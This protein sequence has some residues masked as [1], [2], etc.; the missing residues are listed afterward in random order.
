MITK[1]EKEDKAREL[2][3]LSYNDLCEPDKKQVRESIK[4]KPLFINKIGKIRS[5]GK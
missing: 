2:F 3:N 4:H 1:E 5:E